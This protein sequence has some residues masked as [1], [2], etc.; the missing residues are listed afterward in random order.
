MLKKYLLTMQPVGCVRTRMIVRA[1]SSFHAIDKAWG[2]ADAAGHPYPADTY[3]AARPAT[4]EDIEQYGEWM[5]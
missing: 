4:K 3:V 2:Q 5:I 1:D